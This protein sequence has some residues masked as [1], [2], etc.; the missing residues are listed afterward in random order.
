MTTYRPKPA[1]HD[2]PETVKK[3]YTKPDRK[4]QLAF[5]A[6]LNKGFPRLYNSD[7]SNAQAAI[8][9]PDASVDV[10]HG[11]LIEYQDP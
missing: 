10:V 4:L 9:T 8:K 2:A 5:E 3:A 11:L 7:Y 6:W 1:G